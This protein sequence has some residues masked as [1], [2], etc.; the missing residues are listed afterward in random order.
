MG[1]R[2]QCDF[3]HQ[4]LV[5]GM[6]VKILDWPLVL[7]NKMCGGDVKA[8]KLEKLLLWAAAISIVMGLCSIA[9]R[10]LLGL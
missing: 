5:K 10:L 2:T 7:L 1:R 8:G 9:G 6:R 3:P 4:A